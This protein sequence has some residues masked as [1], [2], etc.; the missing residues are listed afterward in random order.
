MDDKWFPRGR[1][2]AGEGSNIMQVTF[3]ENDI[4]VVASDSGVVVH[5]TDPLKEE[6]VF[7]YAVEADTLDGKYDLLW[8]GSF[9][10]CLAKMGEDMAGNGF[11]SMPL[12]GMMRGSDL[13][14]LIKRV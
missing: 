13:D 5:T 11:I 6:A 14:K 2:P 4:V 10:S 1:V 8:R 7:A 3:D 9:E 12:V